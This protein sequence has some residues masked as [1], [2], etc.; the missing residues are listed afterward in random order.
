V[1]CDP[2]D[3][4]VNLVSTEIEAIVEALCPLSLSV[5][6]S[7]KLLI[8]KRTQETQYDEVLNKTCQDS[9]RSTTN[10]KFQRRRGAMELCVMVRCGASLCATKRFSLRL[11]PNDAYS[12]FGTTEVNTCL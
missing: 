2:E 9:P 11:S 4:E 6:L 1:L 3:N 12:V 8:H 10:D 5:F 7:P